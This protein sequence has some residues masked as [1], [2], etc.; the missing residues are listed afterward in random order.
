M[1]LVD[2]FVVVVV[3]EIMAV[4]RRRWSAWQRRRQHQGIGGLSQQQAV[5]QTAVVCG[6]MQQ[7]WRVAVGFGRVFGFGHSNYCAKK[8]LRKSALNSCFREHFFCSREHFFASRSRFLLW[9][10][11]FGSDN[12]AG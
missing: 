10:A 11:F 8:M 3:T 9:S 12:P 7:Q 5:G 6:G 4:L 1:S 2:I